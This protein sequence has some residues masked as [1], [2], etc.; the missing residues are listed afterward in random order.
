MVEQASDTFSLLHADDEQL[1][2]ELLESGILSD[3]GSVTMQMPP[4]IGDSSKGRGA[5]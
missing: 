1:E 4:K 2:D 3:Q 5:F